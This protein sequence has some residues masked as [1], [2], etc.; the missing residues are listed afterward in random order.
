[1]NFTTLEHKYGL[2]PG[3]LDA[4]YVVE[5][6]RGVNTRSTAGARGPF[7]FMP[8]TAKRFGVANPD[9]LE[10][11]AEGAAK[12]YA[13]LLKR[14]NGDVTKAVAAYNWGEG[15][16][17]KQGLGAA[18]AETRNHVFKI[19]KAMARPT[20]QDLSSEL[21]GSPSASTKATV[22]SAAST[23]KVVV[24]G[25]DLSAELFGK[26]TQPAKKVFK[27]DDEIIKHF[28]YDPKVIKSN[29]DYKPGM[30]VNQLTAEGS[31][32]DKVAKNP[33]G[34]VALG[35]IMGLRDPF[36]AMSEMVTRGRKVIGAANQ[37][38]VDLEELR[39]KVAN[40]DYSQLRNIKQGDID[41]AR[42][43][44]NVLAP[45]PGGK[46]K[47]AS[48][49]ARLGRAA[50]AGGVA[51]AV[52]NPVDTPAG[53][54]DQDYFTEKAKQFG[55]GAVLGPVAQ[56]VVGR[57]IIPGVVK[58]SN[59][60]KGIVK[61]EAKTIADLAS[62]W[63]VQVTY[64]DVTKS[65][66][67]S[68][69]EALMESIPAVGL[70][71]FRRTQQEQVAA[72]GVKLS[73][74]L[75]ERMVSKQ[76][77]GLQQVAD[78]AAKGDKVAIGLLEEVQNA[79]SDW[80]KVVQ[81]SGGLKA[82]RAKLISDRLY[83][84]VA[85]AG[86]EAG[87]TTVATDKTLRALDGAIS[88]L[89]T[90]KVPF[91]GEAK[92][93]EGIRA[94]LAPATQGSV[95]EGV[96]NIGVKTE[97]VAQLNTLRSRTAD[98]IIS[99]V[100]DRY[101]ITVADK[102]PEMQKLALQ[103]TNEELR[104]P[105]GIDT[106]RKF[107]SNLT[108]GSPENVA[109]K[110]RA[111]VKENVPRVGDNTMLMKAIAEVADAEAATAA[112]LSEVMSGNPV[113]TLQQNLAGNK[114]T[115]TFSE[116]RELRSDLG[117]VISGEYQGTT[118]ITGSKLSRVFN[119]VQSA[120]EED[121][122]DYALKSGNERIAKA[123]RRA[124]TFYKTSVVPFKDRAL[125]NAYSSAHPD[126]IYGKFIQTGKGA[127]AEAFYR[128]LDPKGQDAVRYGM[129]DEAVN[130]A[131]NEST[132]LIMPSRLAQALE[133]LHAP[134]KVFFKGEDLWRLKG[135]IKLMRHVERAGLFTENSSAGQRVLP[136]LVGGALNP[137][138]AALGLTASAI[139]KIM[140]TTKQGKAFLLASSK[141]PAG[142]AK[143][144]NLID[145]FT[146]KLPQIVGTVTSNIPANGELS[147]EP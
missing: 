58:A 25:R 38:D 139:A 40:Y 97:A 130:K 57:L 143:L 141:L 118:A 39:H 105:K 136:W 51:S 5:S 138:F 99:D 126:E 20:G 17:E 121:L 109:E 19:R 100:L 34:G 8:D 24:V 62:K 37:S 142:S 133:K 123:W 22:R 120:L 53:M 59:A 61:P 33:V 23:P 76:Y 14:F 74:E 15:N 1:M 69:G 60:L 73:S 113:K 26:S 145:S 93:L 71:K 86:Y 68:K 115:N 18:P 94:K 9:N 43:A 45:L 56:E 104:R 119:T 107:I 80:H 129:I 7:Q 131:M 32:V 52:M 147:P 13:T 30:F 128:S 10:Q 81:T 35:A 95:A 137:Q 92:F 85:E 124:D 55:A 127:R 102:S 12:Y 66:L 83:D 11:S 49:A 3:L 89:K 125:A 106:L 82:F 2:P 87:T 67:A 47:A 41:A 117:A 88:E 96:T 108:D 42:F 134:G 112:K 64:G 90:S 72:T 21:F 44:G 50:L 48:T 63:G 103:L 6:S 135:Y 114:L 146:S 70:S 116:L 122:K 144:Q 28:G 16:V 79:G 110:L 46:I 75:R 84:K 77:S 98:N 36:M 91:T 101:A 78:A 54:S 27:N 65:P 4:T 29:P 31:T 140:F 132:G 111:F